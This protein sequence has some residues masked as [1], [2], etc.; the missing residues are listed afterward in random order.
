MAVF[1]VPDPQTGM[2]ADGPLATI[3]RRQC[4]P[5]FLDVSASEDW[6]QLDKQ[7]PEGPAQMLTPL[8]LPVDGTHA[9]GADIL[10][11]SG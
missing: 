1:D 3:L 2:A 11:P 10:A 8:G 5:H 6:L 4:D 7:V 9:Q